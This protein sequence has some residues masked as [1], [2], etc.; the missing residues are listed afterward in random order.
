MNW[1]FSNAVELL[2]RI[3]ESGL[4]YAE[5]LVARDAFNTGL[6]VGAVRAEI[7]RRMMIS[8]NAI[9]QGIASPKRSFS[10]LTE[11]AAFK[12]ASSP[13]PPPVA[14]RF[15]ALAI[16]YALAVNEVNACGGK[17]V[18][19]PTAGSSGIV[20]GVLWA[21]RDAREPGLISVGEN[22]DASCFLYH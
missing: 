22:H 21:W 13:L 12:V 18:A 19:F 20:P 17:V 16:T 6:E 3:G 4:G 9:E 15:F 2:E 11:G 10:G 7:A 5:W 14:D 8:R 1:K